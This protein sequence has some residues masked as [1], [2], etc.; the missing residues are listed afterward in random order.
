MKSSWRWAARGVP[1]PE[2][3]LPEDSARALGI[4]GFVVR[5]G[6]RGS[7]AQEGWGDGKCSFPEGRPPSSLKH[8]MWH[9]RCPGPGLNTWISREVQTSPGCLSDAAVASCSQ[10][11]LEE[12]PLAQRTAPRVPLPLAVPK[13]HD[14]RPARL[15]AR[16]PQAGAAVEALRPAP[17]AAWAWGFPHLGKGG[18]VSVG[19]R[20]CSL[21][22]A[23]RPVSFPFF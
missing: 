17:G 11:R 8:R 5:P 9:L 16:A 3:L 10:A 19:F 13:N 1:H 18:R 14:L 4:V 23:L 6:L 7:I 2:L 20:E 22:G 15:R 21:T 12:K